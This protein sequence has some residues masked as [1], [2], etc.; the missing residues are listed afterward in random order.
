MIT[1]Y[2]RKSVLICLLALYFKSGICQVDNDSIKYVA[3]EMGSEL[4]NKVKSFNLDQAF[5]LIV[6]AEYVLEKSEK[7]LAKKPALLKSTVEWNISYSSKAKTADDLVWLIDTSSGALMITFSKDTRKST[8]M[9][10]MPKFVTTEEMF[11]Y[12]KKK[13]KITNDEQSFAIK[14]KSGKEA[15]VKLMSEQ[16]MELGGILIMLFP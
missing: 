8:Y 3:V 6:Y 5:E 13:F 10:F 7:Q 2:F 11:N 1:K 15:A 12:L 9:V 14:L 4:H 16:G